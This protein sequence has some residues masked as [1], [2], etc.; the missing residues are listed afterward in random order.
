MIVG[1]IGYGNL[2]RAFCQGWKRADLSFDL[3]VLANRRNME[4]MEKEAA[5]FAFMKAATTEEICRDSHLIL[6]MVKPFQLEDL[7]ASLKDALAGKA[8]ICPA[9]GMS[10]ASLQEL[11]PQSQVLAIMPNVAVQVNKGIILMEQGSS[12]SEG[13]MTM[14]QALFKPLGLVEEQP[15]DSFKAA[16]I[17]GGCAPAWGALV[18]E[19]LADAGVK[20]GLKRPEAIELA[21]WSMLGSSAMVADGTHPALLKDMICSPA[22]TTIRGMEA[23]EKD[24]VRAAFFDAVSAV[25]NK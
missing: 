24:G 14:V 4:A 15:K 23:L 13:Y 12:L 9:A 16:G 7:A 22:G 18:I 17:L 5:D 3:E 6:I 8:I 1:I 19:A 11:F 25:W 10:N 2:A 20:Y 21:A